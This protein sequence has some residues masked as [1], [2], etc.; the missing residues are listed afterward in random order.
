MEGRQTLDA[1]LIANGA[2]DSLLKSN[3]CGL[4]CK[5]DI[6]KTYDHVN[7]NFL[8]L[9]LNKM[10]FGDKWVRWIKWCISIVSFS[11]IV[12]D[13]PLGFFQSSWRLR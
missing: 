3:T 8:L 10:G 6:E 11:V 12:N 1:S 5:L 2:I 7:W 9:V 4:I 13:S